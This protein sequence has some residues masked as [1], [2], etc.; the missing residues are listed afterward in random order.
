MAYM[1]L[2]IAP[3]LYSLLFFYYL[4]PETKNRNLNEVNSEIQNLPK[5]SD[6]PEKLKLSCCRK[7]K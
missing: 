6:L 1:V 2:F 7:D 4:L 3:M 5:I